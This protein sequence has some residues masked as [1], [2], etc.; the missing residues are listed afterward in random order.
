MGRGL[1]GSIDVASVLCQ[2]DLKQLDG[3][4][5]AFFSP[6]LPETHVVGTLDQILYDPFPQEVGEGY[7]IDLR[8]SITLKKRISVWRPDKKVLLGNPRW[9]THH[10]A[11]PILSF[12]FNFVG[13]GH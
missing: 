7:P 9:F 4:R 1:I 2:D 3:L 12:L 8:L 10:S 6:I 5:P 11:H 13:Q